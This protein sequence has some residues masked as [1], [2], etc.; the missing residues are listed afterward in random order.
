MYELIKKRLG[1]IIILII[2]LLLFAVHNNLDAQVFTLIGMNGEKALNYN[3][4]NNGVEMCIGE[5]KV[6]FVYGNQAFGF[7]DGGFQ[8]ITITGDTLEIT[9]KRK[10]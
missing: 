1:W 10:Q 3:H 8:A 9:I 7:K 5:E 4:Y 6:I 2:I